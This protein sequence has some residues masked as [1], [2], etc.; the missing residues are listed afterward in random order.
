MWPRRSS[1]APWTWAK[2]RRT[3]WRWTGPSVPGRGQGVDEEAVAL[4]GGDPAG[5]RV[6][7]GQVA[8]AF[9]GRHV[10]ADGGRRHLDARGAG[11]VGRSDRLGRLDVLGDDGRQD[12]RLARVELV[13]GPHGPVPSARPGGLRGLGAAGRAVRFGTMGVL[14]LDCTECYLGT[15]VRAP[16]GT[17]SR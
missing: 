4:V 17:S 12:G 1:T 6:G 16:E 9:E 7:L 14:A 10:A 11:D 13:L 8:V 3:S 5:A 15:Q 2:K